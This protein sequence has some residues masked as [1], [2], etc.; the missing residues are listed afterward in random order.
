MLTINN[1]KVVDFYKQ[2]PHF[3][4]EQ[5]NLLMVDFLEKIS[6]NKNANRDDLL[7][8]SFKIL[9]SQVSNLNDNIKTSS[10]NIMNLQTTVSNIPNNLSDN[11][12]TNISSIKEN[13]ISQISNI[14]ENQ[15]HKTNL[16]FS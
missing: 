3:D 15:N 2:N 11:I 7:L 9:E 16:L 5:M 10:Q 4:F 1:K 14:L 6:Q 8:Q 13:S 12:S